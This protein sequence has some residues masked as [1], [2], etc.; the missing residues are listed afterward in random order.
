MAVYKRARPE[1]SSLLPPGISPGPGALK[2]LLI[3]V[4][5]FAIGHKGFFL[6][7]VSL[8]TL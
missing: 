1:G 7:F 8:S 4:E 5:N 6:T 3:L 2:N